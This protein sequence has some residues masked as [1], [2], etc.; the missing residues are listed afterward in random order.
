MIGFKPKRLTLLFLCVV[1]LLFYVS[2]LFY[3][4]APDE[5]D[6]RPNILLIVVD[7]LND[8][9][10][11][12]GGHPQ[13]QTPNIDNLAAESIIFTNAHTAAPACGPSRAAM[14]SG[15]LPSTSG[16]YGNRQAKYF[17][18]AWPE[19]ATLPEYLQSQGYYVLGA[20][21]I[22]H[23]ADAKSWDKFY[24]SLRQQRPPEPFQYGQNQNGLDRS[25]FDWGPVPQAREDMSDSKIVDWAGKQLSRG[26][27]SSFLPGKVSNPFFMAVGLYRPHL[28]WYVPQAYF[29]PFPED[30][31]QLPPLNEHDLDDVPA[32]AIDLLDMDRHLAVVRSYQWQAAIRGYLASIHYADD[33][34]GELLGQLDNSAY[35][36]NT[37]VILTSDHGWHLGEK[38]H[39]RK[40]M[41]WERS[42]RVPFLVRYPEKL[43]VPGMLAEQTRVDTPINLLDLFPTVSE[44][45]GI[46]TP[47]WVEGQSIVPLMTRV[48]DGSRQPVEERY[49]ITIRDPNIATVR[50]RHWRLIQY[51]DGAEELYD[52]RNDA[53]EFD[54]VIDDP[55]NAE[56]ADLLRAQLPSE[57]LS[58]DKFNEKVD[59]LNRD[60]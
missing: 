47:E 53:D 29:D 39:W 2:Y 25:Q 60:Q 56:I 35:R 8:W 40:F 15:M 11:Y 23:E 42:T 31:M 41:L 26:I 57:Y 14:F 20:G 1:V 36:D 52:H 55:A 58:V 48:E 24:P 32:A 27:S 59:G 54:N 13:T 22:F 6:G 17:R 51:D 10:G 5:T 9:V 28:P 16:L 45:I 3:Q 37:I 44:M 4:G 33:L 50:S 12:L 49:S 38:R 43:R 18:A 21:K 7:D 46:P 19:I 34:V 30:T